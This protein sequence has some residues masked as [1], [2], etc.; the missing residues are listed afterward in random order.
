MGRW[1]GSRVA[2]RRRPLLS[3]AGAADH[4]TPV[5]ATPWRG[6]VDWGYEMLSRLVLR[7]P[8]FIAAPMLTVA[9]LA[10]AIFASVVVG[11]Y[12]QQTVVDEA[13]PLAMAGAVMLVADAPTTAT[14]AP[15]TLL[16]SPAASMPAAGDTT[17]PTTPEPVAAGPMSPAPVAGPALLRQGQFVSGDPP[18]R[19]SGAARLIRAA[20]GSHILRLE[21]FSVANGP[22]LF[23]IL[24]TDPAGSRGSAAAADAID[25]G[26]LRAT[27]G[28]L[29]YQIP[30]EADL[31]GVRSVIIYCRAF[32]ALFAIATLEVAQ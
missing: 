21:S 30:A 22:D 11:P 28:N 10:T 13:D 15:A 27:S 7:L 12:F 1:T 17:A 24:S 8:W 3:H 23:V 4:Y 14:T 31:A 25:L 20:D 29:N 19:G 9:A 2:P 32:R 26:R 6:I 16:P 5:G 18:Y